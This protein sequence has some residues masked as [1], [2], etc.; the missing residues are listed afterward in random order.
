MPKQSSIFTEAINE[1]IASR[2]VAMTLGT[3]SVASFRT[4]IYR[5][6]KNLSRRGVHLTLKQVPHPYEPDCLIFSL[7]PTKPKVQIKCVLVPKD[8]H[9]CM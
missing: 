5:E 3:F 6:L 2:Q 7:L 4:A 1:L 8:P 9:E